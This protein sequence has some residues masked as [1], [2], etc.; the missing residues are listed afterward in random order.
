MVVFINMILNSQIPLVEGAAAF[1]PYIHH[2][3]QTHNV[4]WKSAAPSG[5]EGKT[6]RLQK[7]NYRC[8]ARFNAL[9][10]VPASF[11]PLLAEFLSWARDLH[12]AIHGL[13]H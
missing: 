1:P 9:A 10:Y 3:T 5:D 2:I 12:L 7:V 11:A 8:K 4:G 13:L 6:Q